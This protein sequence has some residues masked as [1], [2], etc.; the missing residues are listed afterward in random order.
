MPVILKD[1]R[2]PPPFTVC[3]T[4][5]FDDA[6]SGWTIGTYEEAVY[7]YVP[8]SLPEEYKIYSKKENTRPTSRSASPFGSFGQ[9]TAKVKAKWADF[10]LG[11]EYGIIFGIQGKD[12][13]RVTA[14]N[15][16]YRFVVN[17]RDNREFSLRWYDGNQWHPVVDWTINNPVI[18]ANTTPN[19]LEVRCYGAS[20]AIYAND[21]LLWADTLTTTCSGEVGVTSSIASPNAK[22][23]AR[24]DD[25]KVCGEPK[26]EDASSSVTGTSILNDSLS[27]PND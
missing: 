24:F 5:S 2:P 4:D 20:A 16:L 7:S 9:Y 1:Y 3:Y 27:S 6:T 12:N 8:T 10:P 22:T 25:F 23:D 11:D 13:R 26:V 17:T 15:S 18:R 14:A 21:S 19:I